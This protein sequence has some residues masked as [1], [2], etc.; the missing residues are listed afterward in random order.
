MEPVQ[1]LYKTN[2]FSGVPTIKIL[3]HNLL[4]AN[5]LSEENTVS[6]ELERTKLV[7]P[8]DIVVSLIA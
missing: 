5:D 6:G 2:P 8:E 1:K 4:K 7:F 3:D